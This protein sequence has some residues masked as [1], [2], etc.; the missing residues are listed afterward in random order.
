MLLDPTPIKLLN[1]IFAFISA[2]SRVL[3]PLLRA[4]QTPD[5]VFSAD[6]LSRKPHAAKKEKPSKSYVPTELPPLRL[7]PRKQ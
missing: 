7:T 6:F 5:N 3:S 4:K 2:P 1:C